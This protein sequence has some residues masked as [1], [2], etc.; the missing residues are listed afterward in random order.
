MT[1]IAALLALGLFTVPTGCHTN[2]KSKDPQTHRGSLNTGANG[3]ADGVHSIDITVDGANSQTEDNKI[4]DFNQVNL[5]TI[6]LKDGRPVEV[7]FF[8]SAGAGQ[9][10]TMRVNQ[11]RIEGF[12]F[13]D[14]EKALSEL[15]TDVRCDQEGG[16]GIATSE[17]WWFHTLN[18]TTA[19]TRSEP[20]CSENGI[21][22]TASVLEVLQGIIAME[23]SRGEPDECGPVMQEY[24]DSGGKALDE[25]IS[26]LMSDYGKYHPVRNRVAIGEELTTEGLQAIHYTST[27]MYN[28]AD[29][30]INLQDLTLYVFNRWSDGIGEQQQCIGHIPP[31]KVSFSQEQKD[32]LISLIAGTK[33]IEPAA[34]N[35]DECGHGDQYS[36]STFYFG[37]RASVTYRTGTTHCLSAEEASHRSMIDPEL[38][39]KIN[40]VI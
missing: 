5:T 29:F 11:D 34:G 24:E 26:D 2:D 21:D 27:D 8:R 4:T 19:Y 6:N 16:D 9:E 17:T 13:E 1:R 35:K 18:E 36:N 7:L 31:K 23:A 12:F 30:L 15:S 14:L 22:N 38:V 32:S 33:R 3:F 37:D 25:K 20:D 40:E 28:G 39:E 10:L